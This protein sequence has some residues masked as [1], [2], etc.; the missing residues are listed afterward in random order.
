M[1]KERK[2]NNIFYNQSQGTRVRG[3]LKNQGMDCVLLD[4]RKCKIRNWKEQS[5]DRGIWM[6][7]IMEVKACIGL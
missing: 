3:R 1:D 4:I 2:V 7:S 6:R 5:R